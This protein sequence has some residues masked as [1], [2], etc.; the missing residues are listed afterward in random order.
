MGQSYTLNEVVVYRFGQMH[1]TRF[2]YTF[3]FW[4]AI[5]FNPLWNGNPSTVTLTNMANSED[6]AEMPHEV[7]FHQGLLCLLRQN[8]SS[9]KVIQYNI[10]KL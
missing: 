2:S 10:W 5:P 6:P 3:T 7:A 1:N 4:S 8:R 9:E